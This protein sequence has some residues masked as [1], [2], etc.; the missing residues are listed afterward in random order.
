[1]GAWWSWWFMICSCS[2]YY[3]WILW[4]LFSIY[5]WW[6]WYK[7]PTGGTDSDAGEVSLPEGGWGRTGGTWFSRSSSA[8][9]L[10]GCSVFFFLMFRRWWIKIFFDSVYNVITYGNSKSFKFKWTH[11]SCPKRVFNTILSFSNKFFI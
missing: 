11:K 2:G 8:L 4:L 6:S 5:C 3:W 9:D 7:G 1:M 10:S